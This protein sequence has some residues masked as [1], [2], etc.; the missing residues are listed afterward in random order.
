[1]TAL[2][3]RIATVWSRGDDRPVLVTDD[4]QVLS[5]RRLDQAVRGIALRLHAAGVV[6]GQSVICTVPNRSVRLMVELAALRIGADPV[7]GTSPVGLAKAGHPVNWA[8]AEA[9]EGRTGAGVLIFDQDWLDPK[10][11]ENI[12]A[13]QAL[14]R[15]IVS[16]SGST[17]APKW[18][19]IPGAA[20]PVWIDNYAKGGVPPVGRLTLISFPPD[21]TLFG[22]SLALRYWLDGAGVMVPGGS[23]A[24]VL[25]RGAALGLDALS[26]TPLQAAELAS[27]L[28]DG[29]DRPP[30][31]QLMLG[32]AAA[33]RALVAR[34]RALYPG[35]R[36]LLRFGST[37]GGVAA[38]HVDPPTDFTPG[39]CGP[40]VQGTE[41]GILDKGT[42]DP[43]QPEL[44]KV[45]LRMPDGLRTEGYLGGAPCQTKDGWALTGDM[46]IIDGRGH[47]ILTGRISQVLNLGG[48]KIA[49]ERIEDVVVGLP[50]VSQAGAVESDV[51][52]R[53]G[54][55]LVVVP[56]GDGI[57]EA[58]VMAAVRDRLRIVAPMR[59]VTAEA[60]PVLPTG[61]LDRA[62]LARMV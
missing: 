9:S 59:I 19:R 5:G 1:M 41:I 49:P 16:S 11:A 55:A 56:A 25:A 18:M 7:I 20:L 57:N 45:A 32:G 61:K 24:E 33:E 36:V 54:L 27:A 58:D 51:E 43:D 22:F 23:P 34:W 29:A 26:V 39:D 60:L 38:V 12:P 53:P 14:G 13:S 3:H 30:I 4:G 48:S 37:E 52:G 15:L 35:L 40:A 2:M 17:G 47:L 28:E 42:L 50:G 31:A 21:A 6:P 46:G 10:G 62:A 8:V 44:G